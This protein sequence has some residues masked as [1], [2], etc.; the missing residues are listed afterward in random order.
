M[1]V[2]DASN[3]LISKISDNYDPI[4]IFRLLKQSALNDTHVSTL[5]L[6]DST[7]QEY[8]ADAGYGIIEV[9][10]FPLKENQEQYKI[11]CYVTD[12]RV[13][14]KNQI[15]TIL[16]TDLIFIEN[17]QVDRRTPQKAKDKTLHSQRSGIVVSENPLTIEPAGEGYINLTYNGE[18]YKLK[19]Y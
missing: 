7:I 4:D 1:A 14:T 9:R 11:T 5:A 13:M 8:N 2:S 16:Y 17:L 19:T 3:K 15:L 12:N 6:Y 18:T 10:P